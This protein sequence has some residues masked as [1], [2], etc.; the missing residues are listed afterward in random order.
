[1][2]ETFGVII[3]GLNPGIL[4]KK[5]NDNLRSDKNLWLRF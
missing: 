2:R 1:M 5:K 4:D 3:P